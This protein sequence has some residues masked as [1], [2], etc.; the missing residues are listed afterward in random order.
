MIFLG[1]WLLFFLSFCQAHERDNCGDGPKRR[2]RGTQA[3]SA[4]GSRD[5]GRWG[6]GRPD[7]VP[8]T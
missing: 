6:A 4:Q 1:R 8:R 2:K 3:D 7:H 5:R